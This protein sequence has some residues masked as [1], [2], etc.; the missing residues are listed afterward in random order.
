MMEVQTVIRAVAGYMN[1][2]HSA[3]NEAS[4]RAPLPAGSLKMKYGE[5]CLFSI[6]SKN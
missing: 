1:C 5:H 3:M 4:K 6:V 2:R